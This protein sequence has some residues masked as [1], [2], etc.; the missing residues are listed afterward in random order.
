MSSRTTSRSRSILLGIGIAIVAINMRT[1]IVG[2]GPLLDVIRLDLGI[3]TTVA[4]LLT[5]IPVVCFGLL[6]GFAPRLS[7][8]FGIDRMLWLTMVGLTLGIL[9][10]IVPS[11]AMLFAG[12]IVIGASIAIANVLAPAV[13]KRDFPGQF[14]LMTGVYTMG[15]SIGGATA[16]GLMVPIH[17]SGYGWRQALGLLAIPA[18][19]AVIVQLPR[20]RMERPAANQRATRRAP[21]LWGNALAWQVSLF[22]GLQ[23]FV[24]FGLAA[25]IP[26]ILHDAGLSREAAG[27]MWAIGN[28]AGLPASLVVPIVAQRIPNQRPLLVGLIAIWAMGIA[29]ILI[30]PATFTLAWMVLF[31]LGAGSALSLALMLIVL[32]S[33]DT[34]HAASLSGMAQ[35]I[36][37]TI[38]AFAPFLGGLAHDLTGDW[39]ASIFLMLAVLVPTTFMGWF[40]SRRALVR[41]RSVRP[42]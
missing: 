28:L 3:S 8:R 15:I 9:I 33:P 37:Y 41:S 1:A 17:E 30:A 34:A 25:W 23:S 35:A 6:A 13:I 18:L 5:T 4:G 12:T 10:R 2:V 42:I 31:G 16:T 21:R 14:G 19:V 7:T 11:I 26:T 29:G 24:Y 22:M 32:R 27:T 40:A 38:A 39:T 36:G 20:L